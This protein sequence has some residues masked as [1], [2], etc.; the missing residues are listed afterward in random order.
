MLHWS[1][2]YKQVIENLDEIIHCFPTDVLEKIK[3]YL[4]NYYSS[5]LLS[6]I[7]NLKKSF[8]YNEKTTAIGGCNPNAIQDIVENAK[9]VVDNSSIASIRLVILTTLKNF[10][11]NINKIYTLFDEID[12]IIEFNLDANFHNNDEAYNEFY[13][14]FTYMNQLLYDT[15]RLIICSSIFV[16]FAS[17]KHESLSHYFRKLYD[18]IHS[19]KLM[20]YDLNV[21]HRRI[22]PQKEVLFKEEDNLNCYRLNVFTFHACGLKYQ[23]TYNPEVDIEIDYEIYLTDLENDIK[24]I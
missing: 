23:P 1:N 7:P 6:Y 22:W 14:K 8:K 12:N 4:N 3:D 19:F 2:D 15:A 18:Y 10:D 21:H 20:L 17:K 13:G 9:E 16:W 11:L 24:N 5:K